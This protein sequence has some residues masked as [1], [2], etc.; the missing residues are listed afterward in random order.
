MEMKEKGRG[1]KKL[2]D[3]I[4]MGESTLALAL[5]I[6]GLPSYC[7][8][9]RECLKVHKAKFIQIITCFLRR[10]RSILLIFE[11]SQIS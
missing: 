7:F 8:K 9:G 2:G 6:P 10:K 11:I 5:V 1:I 3:S 4:P